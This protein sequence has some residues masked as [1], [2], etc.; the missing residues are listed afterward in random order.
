[1]SAWSP[2][3]EDFSR[4]LVRVLEASAFLVQIITRTRQGVYCCTSWRFLVFICG[5]NTVV[6]AVG[7]HLDK[8]NRFSGL[9]VQQPTKFEGLST[10]MKKYRLCGLLLL[11]EFFTDAEII[12]CGSVILEMRNGVL[13]SFCA[14]IVAYS[15]SPKWFECKID[16]GNQ[17]C[18]YFNDFFKT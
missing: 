8:L 17:F 13:S 12:V 9:C 1:M 11:S 5:S 16:L 10:L 7:R 3:P 15:I 14:F 6:F 18:R 4:Q 2:S